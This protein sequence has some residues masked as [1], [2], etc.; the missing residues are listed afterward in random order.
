MLRESIT[1]IDKDH[2]LDLR[3]LDLTSTD[4][5]ALFGLSPY[6]THFELWHRKKSC[7]EVTIQ[8]TARMRWGNRL[9]ASIA[10]GICEDNGWTGK[11]F[12][13]YVRLPE[14]C[15]GSSFDWRIAGPDG[16][17]GDGILEIKT[18]D[19]RAFKSGWEFE[20]DQLVAPAHIE[21]QVQHQM[22]VAG[23]AWAKIGALVG[24]NEVHVLHRDADPAVHRAILAK[25]AEFWRSIA[26][27]R[28]PPPVYPDDAAAVIALHSHAEPTTVIDAPD[29]AELIAEYRAAGADEKAAQDRK[30]TAKARILERIGEAEKARCG[31]FTI[32]AGITPGHTYTVERQP[33]RAF[34]ITERKGKS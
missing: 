5:A 14:H 22:L 6:L 12:K 28:E 16:G 31:Q 20:D 10:A 18:V 33:F 13:D 2:W 11:P 7:A 29:L 27:N 4:V 26:E 9:E 3:R 34:R 17:D 1:P 8:E 23:L 21:L 30:T 25:A 19:L 32:S 24:G 15:L